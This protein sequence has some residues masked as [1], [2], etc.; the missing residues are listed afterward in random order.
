MVR[1]DGLGRFRY[2]WD[3]TVVQLYLIPKAGGKLTVSVQHTKL[4]GIDSVE[5]FRGH[6][7]TALG[8]LAALF[9]AH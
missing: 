2:T 9:E 1:P 7:R 6:W 5:R 8:A 3:G 4:P